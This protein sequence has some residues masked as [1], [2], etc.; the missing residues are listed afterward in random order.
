MTLSLTDSDSDQKRATRDLTVK[1]SGSCQLQSNPPSSIDPSK[2]GLLS[3]D[4]ISGQ[5]VPMDPVRRRI[6]PGPNQ[7]NKKIEL[8]SI[9]PNSGQVRR[10]FGE[11]GESY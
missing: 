10:E 11:I 8:S 3:F 5:A 6:P 7:L 2:A 1:A 4:S 9:P